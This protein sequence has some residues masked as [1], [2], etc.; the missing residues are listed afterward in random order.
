[1]SLHEGIRVKDGGYTEPAL[2]WALADL[3]VE[4]GVI[5]RH[6]TGPRYRVAATH[7]NWSLR[8]VMS[9]ERTAREDPQRIMSSPGAKAKYRS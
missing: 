1:M 2:H 3:G 4:R 8:D 6:E 9:K 5:T 7:M